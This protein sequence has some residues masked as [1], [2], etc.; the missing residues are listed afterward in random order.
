MC[1][2]VGSFNF[3]KAKEL[4]EANYYRGSLNHSISYID[5]ESNIIE[6]NR[7]KGPLDLDNILSYP[8]K[9]IIVHQQAPT[10]NSNFIHPAEFYSQYL[11]HNGLL[12]FDCVKKFKEKYKIDNIWDTYYILREMQSLNFTEL[13][14]S[15]ACLYFKDNLYMFR[16]NLSPLYIDNDLN[17][18]STRFKDS[19]SLKSESLFHI[20]LQNK[21]LIEVLQFKTIETPYYFG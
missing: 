2:I 16:N 21:H 6:V 14:G 12:K 10:Q 8:N 9:Y 7:F 20:D 19:I 3:K 5:I 4:C 18:S 17:V 15:Y 11:W 1:S 13:D